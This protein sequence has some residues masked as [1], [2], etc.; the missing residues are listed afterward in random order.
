MLNPI[1]KLLD[2][3]LSYAD[4]RQKYN[5][6]GCADFSNKLQKHFRSFVACSYDLSSKESVSA[7]VVT[8][9]GENA[10]IV[11]IFTYLIESNQIKCS[12]NV[13]E[14]L[15]GYEP[16]E[17]AYYYTRIDEYTS[18]DE[19]LKSSVANGNYFLRLMSSAS[20]TLTESRQITR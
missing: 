8:G 13:A 16:Y 19:A 20:M 18:F 10:S 17:L 4:Y 15:K 5:H 12:V 7:N 14:F 1:Q 6:S 9:I 3:K 2:S 11:L